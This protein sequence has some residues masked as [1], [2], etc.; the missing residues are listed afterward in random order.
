MWVIFTDGEP[1][2]GDDWDKAAR[3]N[4]ERQAKD[5]KEM[6]VKVYTIGLL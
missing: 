5:L 4:A 1:T 2:G 3:R 6:G